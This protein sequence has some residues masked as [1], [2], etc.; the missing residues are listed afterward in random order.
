MIDLI[1]EFCKNTLI[2]VFINCSVIIYFFGS[3]QNEFVTYFL[4]VK[5][6]KKTAEN[7][8]KTINEKKIGFYLSVRCVN[9][10]IF[11]LEQNN[12]YFMEECFFWRIFVFSLREGFLQLFFGFDRFVILLL[13]DLFSAR[14]FAQKSGNIIASYRLDRLR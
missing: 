11:F 4:L 12:R 2:F 9:I 8:K 1:N 3:S 7:T 6:T 5:R 14:N 10:E 13:A